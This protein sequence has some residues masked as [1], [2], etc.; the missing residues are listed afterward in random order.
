[1]TFIMFEKSW[2][3]HFTNPDKQVIIKK[4]KKVLK[5]LIVNTTIY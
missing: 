1:M 2:K 3:N 5:N 4:L